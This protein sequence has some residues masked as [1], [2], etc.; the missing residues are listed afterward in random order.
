VR[1][2]R[3]LFPLQHQVR[4][5]LVG[6]SVNCPIELTQ[7]LSV[8]GVLQSGS[9]EASIAG[10]RHA[11]KVTRPGGS[12]AHSLDPRVRLAQV[13]DRGVEPRTEPLHHVEVF[14]VR[15]VPHDFHKVSNLEGPPLSS[16][17]H[18]LAPS[19]HTAWRNGVSTSATVST[20]TSWT[21]RS[22]K[23]YS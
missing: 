14:R 18:A 3:Y 8:E 11:S 9:S 13:E 12:F 4:M 21:H 10:S 22:P 6:H 5:P 1:V 19:R 2:D 17:G 20:C 15:D 7:T 16:G 23:S